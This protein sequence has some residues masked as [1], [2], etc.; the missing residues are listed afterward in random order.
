MAGDAGSSLEGVQL[1]PENLD[2]DCWRDVVSRV[3]AIVSFANDELAGQRNE[4]LIGQIN[5][6]RSARSS[7][8]H[9]CVMKRRKLSSPTKLKAFRESEGGTRQI[10]SMRW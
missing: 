4:R 5:N 10:L 1:R 9:A 3:N 2:E 7:D 6:A 8:G